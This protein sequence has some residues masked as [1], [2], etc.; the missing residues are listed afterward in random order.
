MLTN[1]LLLN[2]F[3]VAQSIVLIAL[4][5]GV[6]FVVTDLYLRTVVKAHWKL[7]TLFVIMAAIWRLPFHDTFFHGLE[8]EDSYV[9]TVSARADL[10]RG[11]SQDVGSVYLTSTCVAGSLS[12]C[13]KFETYS[14][15][16]IGWPSIIRIALRLFRYSPNLPIYLNILGSCASVVFIFLIC[17]LAT[18]GILAPSAA[19]VVFAS[20]PA[21]AVYGVATYAEPISNTCI[22]AVVLFAFRYLYRAHDAPRGRIV[23]WFALTVTLLLATLIKRENVLLAIGLL[24]IVTICLL[25]RIG[26]TP[27]DKGKLCWVACS[28]AIVLVF[29]VTELQLGRTLISETQEFGHFP[30]SILNAKILLVPFLQACVSAKWYSC[31]FVFVLLGIGDAV[32]R[33][34]VASV[35]FGFLLS[36]V[37]LYTF[38]VHS[39]Y[40]VH[41]EP[42]LPYE[43]LRFAMNLMTLYS[44]L[45]GLGVAAMFRMWHAQFAKWRTLA[46]IGIFV[47]AAVCYAATA[48]LRQEAHEAEY[49]VRVNPALA[50][51]RLAQASVPPTYIATLE[52][53]VVQIFA[54]RTI[55]VIGLYAI[56]QQLLTTLRNL[57]PGMSIVYLRQR[58]YATPV[59]RNRYALGL[60]CL[61]SQRQVLLRSDPNFTLIQIKMPAAGEITCERSTPFEIP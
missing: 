27:A 30:F 47:Y 51:V 11:V 17:Y 12:S 15:H 57:H 42:V 14:G 52:P 16:Y 55:N 32:R 25:R 39:Y 50:V 1:W 19:A 5:S 24:L 49:A 31:T 45:A 41:G 58:Q 6:V 54:P 44:I 29:S 48:R 60:E 38:H 26:T 53:L 22:S 46:L 2:P 40:Q 9:Y 7:I 10:P 56:N 59:A 35:A 33:K 13:E 43:T 23:N 61:D 34:S 18:D 20:T 28:C 36:Y 37:L 8:Y 4:S 3:A 21:F